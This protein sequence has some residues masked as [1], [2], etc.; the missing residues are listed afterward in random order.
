MFYV[1]FLDKVLSTIENKVRKFWE[2]DKN[3][4]SIFQKARIEF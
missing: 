2:M 1:K 3:L 4:L